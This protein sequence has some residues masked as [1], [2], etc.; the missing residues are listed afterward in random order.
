MDAT[1]VEVL[2]ALSSMAGTTKTVLETI[3]TVKA[4]VK[5]AGAAAQFEEALTEVRSIH[6]QF[7][8]IEEKVRSLNR[9]ILRLDE[10]NAQLRRQ[11]A[12]LREEIGRKEEWA[13]ERKKYQEKKIGD[14]VVLVREDSPNTYYCA[15]CAETKKQ[16]IVIQGHPMADVGGFGSH[17]CPVCKT[18]L[19]LH[20]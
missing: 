20:G 17:R 10:E 4:G 18:S 13:A 14:A 5:N 8:A 12:Q 6:S 9:E 1:V 19:R 16:L 15:T 2:A 3:K 11:E 7:V